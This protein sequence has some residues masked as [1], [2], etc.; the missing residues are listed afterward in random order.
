MVRVKVKSGD[1]TKFLKV[2]DKEVYDLNIEIK[3]LHL[4]NKN[5]LS[6]KRKKGLRLEYI[7]NN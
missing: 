5:N 2:W 3:N 4:K 6:Y 7:S 1:I